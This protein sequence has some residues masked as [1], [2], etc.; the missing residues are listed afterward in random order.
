MF[1][2]GQ[3]AHDHRG[4][5][6]D[7]LVVAELSGAATR[8]A[9]WRDLSEA[10]TAAAV[11]ELREIAAGRADLLAEVAGILL[12]FREGAP[13]EP[14]AKAAAQLCRLAGAD[15]DLILQWAEEGRRRAAASRMM[16]YSGQP[17]RYRRPGR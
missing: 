16:P 14:K 10:E 4:P 15:E 5:D 3:M 17:G 8:H 7:R 11:A 9:R 13:E 6:R 2:P 1:D 12:G